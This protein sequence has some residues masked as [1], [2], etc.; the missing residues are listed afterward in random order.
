MF[1]LKQ[2]VPLDSCR[3]FSLGIGERQATLP[4]L[5]F[6]EK[7]KFRFQKEIAF[8]YV[9]TYDIGHLPTNTISLGMK[10]KGGLDQGGG[11]PVP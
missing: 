4:D 8:L 9:G 6:K 11:T 3:L 10:Y 2:A 7:P 1:H 5:T